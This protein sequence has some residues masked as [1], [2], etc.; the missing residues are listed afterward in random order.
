MTWEYKGQY[1]YED[2]RPRVALSKVPGSTGTREER[3][4]LGQRIAEALNEKAERKQ[5]C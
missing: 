4:E 5:S 1:L 2:G 3:D